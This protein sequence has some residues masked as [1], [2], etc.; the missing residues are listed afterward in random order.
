MRFGLANVAGGDGLAQQQQVGFVDAVGAAVVGDPLPQ[1]FS[2][3]GNQRLE[4]LVVPVR[5]ALAGLAP[6]I[7]DQL[8][9]RGV[10]DCLVSAVR[11]SS[12]ALPLAAVQVT[13]VARVDALEQQQ[14]F[15]D[16]SI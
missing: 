5:V 6:Q 14:I 4:Q 7:D 8:L 13:L 11:S 1:H 15:V 12:A 2:R 9:P 10:H 16:R 3:A